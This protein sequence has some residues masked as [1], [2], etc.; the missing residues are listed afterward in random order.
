MIGTRVG[1][2]CMISSLDFP[3]D[4]KSRGTMQMYG[5]KMTCVPNRLKSGTQ[6]APTMDER[7]QV[8]AAYF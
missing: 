6:D 2:P 3:N 7:D 5:G 1:D 4:F 8:Y